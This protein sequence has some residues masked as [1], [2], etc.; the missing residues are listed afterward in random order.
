VEAVA[1]EQTE[2]QVVAVVELVVEA[3]AQRAVGYTHKTALVV[4]YT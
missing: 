4:A 3:V 2:A 1:R